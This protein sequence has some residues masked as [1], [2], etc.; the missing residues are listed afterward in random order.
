MAS[1]TTFYLSRIIDT[2]A[3]DAHGN[4]IGVVKD[5]LVD[6]ESSSYTSGHPSV[7]G[8]KIKQKKRT[9]FLAFRHF[10]IEK[11]TGKLKV[12]CDKLDE[13]SAE[14]IENDLYLVDSVLDK[15]IVDLNGRKLVRVNDVRLVSIVNGTYEVAFDIGIEGLLRRVGIARPF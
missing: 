14:H 15:Q 1:F 8:I 2:K 13:L 5:L 9:L 6:S 11:S 7:N 12:V 4:C 10:R 3:F